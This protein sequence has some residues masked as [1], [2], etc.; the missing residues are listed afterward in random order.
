MHFLQFLKSGHAAPPGG[1]LNF[2]KNTE[3]DCSDLDMCGQRFHRNCSAELN[4]TWY[5]DSIEGV[6]NA[7]SSIF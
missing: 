7:R 5:N 3:L 2:S 1:R 4:E 6:V